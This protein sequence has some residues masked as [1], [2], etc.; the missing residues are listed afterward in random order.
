MPEKLTT[1]RFNFPTVPIGYSKDLESFLVN[2]LHQNLRLSRN[3]HSLRYVL[4]QMI[5]EPKRE[6]LN[7]AIES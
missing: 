6:A 7:K 2:R 1:T 3:Y 5:E 4:T